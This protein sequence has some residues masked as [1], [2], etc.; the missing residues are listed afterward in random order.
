MKGAMKKTSLLVLA[1]LFVVSIIS[2]SLVRIPLASASPAPYFSVVSAV[3]AGNRAPQTIFAR[4]TSVNF[5]SLI[6]AVAYNVTVTW[7]ITLQEPD[8]SIYCIVS[9]PIFLN[10]T[11]GPSTVETFNN[12]TVIQGYFIWTSIGAS[13]TIFISNEAPPGAWNAYLQLF[14]SDG[15]TP[16]AIAIVPFAVT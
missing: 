9:S 3:N 12:G 5:T 8:E 7:R 11:H 2:M 1:L 16:Y 13:A 6:Y 15:V 14:A 4:G 10:P